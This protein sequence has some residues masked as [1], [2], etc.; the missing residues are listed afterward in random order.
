MI[1]L[2]LFSLFIHGFI[3]T[4]FPFRTTLF[5]CSS[6]IPNWLSLFQSSIESIPILNRVYSFRTLVPYT[7]LVLFQPSYTSALSQFSSLTIIYFILGVRSVSLT[8]LV[9]MSANFRPPSHQLIL[10]IL[11]F[12]PFLNNAL[13]LQCVW[14]VLYPYRSYTCT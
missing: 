5:S 2:L 6:N 14:Y 13:S 1:S 10:C 3:S 8:L 11:H 4:L 9:P 12:Y 7:I